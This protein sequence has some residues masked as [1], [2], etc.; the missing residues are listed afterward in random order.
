[1]LI[2]R[3]TQRNKIG[4]GPGSQ[5]VSESPHQNAS[6]VVKMWSNGRFS[7]QKISA[8]A[9]RWE[10][11]YGVYNPMPVANFPGCVVYSGRTLAERWRGPREVQ[12]SFGEATSATSRGPRQR[13]ANGVQARLEEL[14]KCMFLKTS[15]SFSFF[16]G[17]ERSQVCRDPDRDLEDS[18]AAGNLDQ[19][20]SSIDS[21]KKQLLSRDGVAI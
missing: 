13:S 6:A 2:H 9:R 5:S 20:N 12:P 7:I 15:S 19:R 11:L 21:I 18:R 10:F 1:M 17:R 4:H 16:T 14:S 8:R 3:R